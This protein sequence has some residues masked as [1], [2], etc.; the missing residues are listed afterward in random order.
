MEACAEVGN[1]AKKTW[2]AL[3][4]QFQYGFFART[5]L[6]ASASIHHACISDGSP[7]GVEMLQ[8]T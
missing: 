2:S 3:A 8:D 7:V 1:V 4:K 5:R 6:T